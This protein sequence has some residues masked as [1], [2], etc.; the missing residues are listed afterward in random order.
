MWNPSESNPQH[1]GEIG[2]DTGYPADYDDGWAEEEIAFL[3]AGF[4]WPR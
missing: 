3:A 4:V 2:W 1:S